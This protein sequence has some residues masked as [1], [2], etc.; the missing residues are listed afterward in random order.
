MGSRFAAHAVRV[1]RRGGE[2]R[3]HPPRRRATSASVPRSRS[4]SSPCG[5]RRPRRA[6]PSRHGRRGGIRIG[7]FLGDDVRS[8]NV[9]LA[10][11]KCGRD[12]PGLDLVPRRFDRILETGSE[13][14]AFSWTVAPDVVERE[15]GQADECQARVRGRRRTPLRSSLPA[16]DRLEPRHDEDAVCGRELVLHSVDLPGRSDS[17]Y[18]LAARVGVNRD[19]EHGPRQPVS[20]PR[21]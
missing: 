9:W 7:A 14:A 12:A 19:L 10:L 3:A 5:V 18:R 15:A 4:G 2:G 16:P 17:A 8:L 1:P 6:S 20:P 13:G 11:S 21:A